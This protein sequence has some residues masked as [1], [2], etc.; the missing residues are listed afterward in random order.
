M[1]DKL[2][3][4]QIRVNNIRIVLGILFTIAF[5]TIFVVKNLLSDFYLV[6]LIA[7]T[8]Y[9]LYAYIFIP[10]KKNKKLKDQRNE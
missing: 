5:W 6:L 1:E 4:T 2:I 9:T 8:I 7:F 10:V 3:K